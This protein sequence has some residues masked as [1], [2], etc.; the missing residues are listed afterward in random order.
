MTRVSMAQM[1]KKSASS[2]FVS[3]VQRVVKGIRKGQVMTYGAVATKAGFPGAA[4]AV[5][6]LMKQNYD[7]QIP[8]HRVVRADGSL[9]DYNRGGTKRK[10]AILKKEGVVLKNGRAVVK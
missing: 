6:S 4:R 3:S 1:S 7:P 9:G 10:A 2:S 5:G 8:C